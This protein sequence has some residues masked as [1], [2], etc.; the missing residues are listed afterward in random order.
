VGKNGLDLINRLYFRV[1]SL[2]NRKYEVVV[3][4]KYTEKTVARQLI[5]PSVTVEST[6]LSLSQ[7]SEGTFKTIALI[8][9]CFVETFS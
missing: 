9:Y 4:G 8:F 6:Q 5:I 1:L 3:G 7:L 2:P